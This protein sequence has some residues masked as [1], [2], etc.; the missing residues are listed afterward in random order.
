MASTGGTDKFTVIVRELN[1]A[2]HTHG[3][4][5]IIAKLTG[6]SDDGS[7]ITKVVTVTISKVAAGGSG[8]IPDGGSSTPTKHDAGLSDDFIL[9]SAPTGRTLNVRDY[10]ATS[11]NSANNDATAIQNAIKAATAGDT[12]YIPNGTYHVSSVITLKSGVS[13]IGESREGTILAGKFASSVY[14]VVRVPAGVND[15]TISSFSI[16][17]SSGAS[18]KAGV[19]L[20]SEGSTLVSRIAVKDLR[21]ENFQRFGVQLTN[22][23]QVLVD[24]NQIRNASAPVSY[25]HLTLPTMSLVCRSRWSPYH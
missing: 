2:D 3:L 12:V 19:S 25:T 18:F 13:L 20:G 15:L 24:G 7:W 23:Y 10:G 8:A 5:G 9:P 11:N 14:A 6:S 1:A 16:I 21:I 22:A 4:K 17:K